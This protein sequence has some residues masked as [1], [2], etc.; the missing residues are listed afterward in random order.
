MFIY[1]I[2]QKYTRKIYVF[3]TYKF[4]QINSEPKRK[5]ILPCSK[6]KEC[7]WIIVI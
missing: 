7:C 2:F 5:N 6:V 4:K 1:E 3:I